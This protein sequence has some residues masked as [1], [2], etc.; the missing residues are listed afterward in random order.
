[1]PARIPLPPHVGGSATLTASGGIEVEGTRVGRVG[2]ADLSE[3]VEHTIVT[4]FGSVAHHI[5]FFNGGELHYTFNSR[6]ELVE[7]GGK[8]VCAVLKANGDY[9]VGAYR[10]KS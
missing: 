10:P 2:I 9:L 4:I 3:V 5:R 8:N 7:L 6:G 1:M